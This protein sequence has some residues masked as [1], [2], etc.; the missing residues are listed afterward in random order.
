MP[1]LKAAM[2]GA[3]L[4]AR[5]SRGAESILGAMYGLN[6]CLGVEDAEAWEDL[7]AR[8]CNVVTGVVDGREQNFT[9]SVESSRIKYMCG[10]RSNIKHEDGFPV[11]FSAPIKG[12]TLDAGDFRVML[13][14]GSEAV[15]SCATLRPANEGNEGNT[16]VLIGNFGDG[17]AGT[18]YPVRVEVKGQLTLLPY[19]GG[20]FEAQGLSFEGDMGYVSDGGSRLHMVLAWLETF[21]TKGE[22]RRT[23][24][25]SAFPN[26]CRQLYG[27]SVTHRIR[28]VLNGGGFLD[29]VRSPLPS[30]RIFDVY[31][32]GV[33]VG[34]PHFL[35]LADLGS[36]SPSGSNDDNSYLSDGDNFFDL[37][38]A[39]PNGDVVGRIDSVR[40]PCTEEG[41]VPLWPPKGRMGG[42][43]CEPHS[44]PVSLAGPSTQQV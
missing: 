27:D 38:L 31:A 14:D 9:N 35:G 2:A 3:F 24:R 20:S 22:A 29:G 41:G 19:A 10:L 28:V 30:M 23:L 8:G 39:D 15:P 21:S 13:S 43:A 5:A 18:L 40:M 1:M 7:A 44:I 34:E 11:T 4:L 25:R 32:G 17:T 37:C 6:D 33:L 16:A 26:H 42:R 12:S 36:E